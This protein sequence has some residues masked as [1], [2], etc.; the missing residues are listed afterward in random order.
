MQRSSNAGI[1]REWSP[2][3]RP[4]V[5]RLLRRQPGTLRRGG[6]VDE[7]GGHSWRL[8]VVRL[9][10]CP[11]EGK[12]SRR[13]EPVNPGTGLQGAVA[14]E[15]VHREGRCAASAEALEGGVPTAGRR[16]GATK[17]AGA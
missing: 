10:E 1:F 2:G 8:S 17:A 16:G 14:E 13:A 9:E 7:A 3:G 12:N 15:A 5:L 11:A 4:P 6:R